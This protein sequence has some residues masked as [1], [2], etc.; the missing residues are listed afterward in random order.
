LLIKHPQQ[1]LLPL[2]GGPRSSDVLK[3]ENAQMGF[4]SPQFYRHVTI[5]SNKIIQ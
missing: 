1:G 3:I 5:I 4:Q 2:P